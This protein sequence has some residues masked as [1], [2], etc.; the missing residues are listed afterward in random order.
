MALVEF[1]QEKPNRRGCLLPVRE[2]CSNIDGNLNEVDM[3]YGWAYQR[4][5]SVET[6]TGEEDTPMPMHLYR[7]ADRTGAEWTI[8]ETAPSQ[9]EKCLHG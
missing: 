9:S 6:W 1:R 3:F 2:V 7:T 5:I 8:L 4:H